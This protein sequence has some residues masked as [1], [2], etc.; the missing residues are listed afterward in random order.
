MPDQVNKYVATAWGNRQENLTDLT[1][2][3]GQVCQ[4][5]RPGVEGLVELG[6]LD[7]VDSLT[8]I[9]HTDHIKR[10]QGGEAAVDVQ[11]LAKDPKALKNVLNTMND[12][13]VAVVVQPALSHIPGKG[14]ERQENVIYTDMVALED[15]TF[16]MQYAIGGSSDLEKFRKERAKNAGSVANVQ[17]IRPAPKPVVRRKSSR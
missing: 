13:V 5:R 15:K 16:I 17:Q 7:N 14:E 10:V 2:P 11:A 8:S 3:S 1:C 4:V 6:V 12:I 9:V